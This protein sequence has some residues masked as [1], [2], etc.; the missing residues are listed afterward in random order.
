MTNQ[1]QFDVA[2][3]EVV[4]T[5]TYVTKRKMPV[6]YVSHEIDDEE[7]VLWQFHCGNGDF[8]ASVLQLVRLDELIELDAGLLQIAKLPVGHCAK[9]KS[10]NAMW[11]IEKDDSN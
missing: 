7:G 1:W 8:S 3:D 4:V 5:T 6:L 11:S 9:R 10:I 2:P